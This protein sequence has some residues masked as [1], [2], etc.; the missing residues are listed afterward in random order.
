[1]KTLFAF[2]FPCRVRAAMFN[3]VARADAAYITLLRFILFLVRTPSHRID[4][5]ANMDSFRTIGNNQIC[6]LFDS[7][8]TSDASTMNFGF[9]E[10]ER[11]LER[12]LRA[13][14]QRAHGS[15]GVSPGGAMV[16]SRPGEGEAV[17]ADRGDALSP[18]A[19]AP[20]AAEEV[21]SPSEVAGCCGDAGRDV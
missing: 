13:W 15:P 11:E 18:S 4:T 1:M 21:A 5:A 10:L 17:A 19:V 7:N 2:C 3:R 12:R 6:V 9:S 14:P 20:L 16:P 8:S